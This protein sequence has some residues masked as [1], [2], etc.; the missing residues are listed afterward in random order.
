L[1]TVIQLGTRSPGRPALRPLYAALLTR[2]AAE[3]SGKGQHDEALRLVE[4]CLRQQPQ[5]TIH[6]LNRAA[7][8][9]LLADPVP[10]Y[11]AW[12][13][14]NTHQYRKHAPVPPRA[15]RFRLFR[16]ILGRRPVNR[17]VQVG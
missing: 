1:Q 6:Y 7:I 3:L 2:E 14:L 16:P 11:E 4:I 9:T 5:E 15:P 17:K 8:F 10:Y 12:A 13:A